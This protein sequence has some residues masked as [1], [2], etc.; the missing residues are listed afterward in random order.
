[1]PLIHDIPLFVT[2]TFYKTHSVK[3][4]YMKPYTP[5]PTLRR[6]VGNVYISIDTKLNRGPLS[7]YRRPFS[8]RLSFLS[9]QTAGTPYRQYQLQR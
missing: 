5:S 3:I 7:K 1:M 9:P 8:G 4:I 6:T 2:R